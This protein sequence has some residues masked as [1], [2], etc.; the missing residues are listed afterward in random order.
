[1]NI[2]S[3][4]TTLEVFEDGSIFF[5]SR[6]SDLFL[7]GHQQPGA[8]SPNQQK[9]V[10]KCQTLYGLLQQELDTLDELFTTTSP[11]SRLKSY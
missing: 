2:T 6:Q 1:L 3:G 10:E 8:L 5:K 9:G 11:V 4:D 7:D